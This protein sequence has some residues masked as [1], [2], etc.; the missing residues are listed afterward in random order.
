MASVTVAEMARAS[1]T[2]RLRTS[3]AYAL[4]VSPV[5]AL[6]ARWKCDRLMPAAAARSS[7][8]AGSPR[9]A[10]V[11]MD[12]QAV[13]TAAA[14]RSAAGASSGRH[15]RQGRKPACSAS[16]VVAWKATFSRRGRRA[17]HDGRQYTPVV[18]TE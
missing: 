8:G 13:A 11:S 9:S 7:T 3:V 1:R 15:R 12:R 18:R 17:A 2:R 14:R 16:T 10:A 4:G 5:T 6:N